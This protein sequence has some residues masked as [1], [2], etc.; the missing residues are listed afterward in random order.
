MTSFVLLRSFPLSFFTLSHGKNMKQIHF[1]TSS[2]FSL[3]LLP[4]TM[5]EDIRSVVKDVR[6]AC[7]HCKEIVNKQNH[8]CI[9]VDDIRQ[10]IV[11]A[12]R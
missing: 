2:A 11:L 9:V 12:M 4:F 8:I 3:S 1:I 6:V 7:V 10:A 5:G